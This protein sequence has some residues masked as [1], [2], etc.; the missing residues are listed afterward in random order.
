MRFS[1]AVV[2]IAGGTGGLGAAVSEAFAREGAN[3]VVTYRLAE[4]YQRLTRQLQGSAERLSGEAV[5][6]TDEA[7]TRKFL[8]RVQARYSRVDAL[9][10]TV[11]GYVGGS[12]LWEVEPQVLTRMF[13]INVNPFHSLVRAAL[14]A[15]LARGRGALVNV[16]AKAAIDHPAGAAAYAA[17]KAAALAMTDALAAELHGTG[18]RVNCVL[19]SVIDTPANRQAMPKANFAQWPKPADIAEVILFLC[20]DAARV[21]HGAAI[22]V[23]GNA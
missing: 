18:V 12:K 8:E 21:V 10:N 7:A 4:E 15:F 14:P 16:A 9:V 5:D 22:P 23:Y 2:I 17:S 11:G 6:V 20:S 1:D 19:P 13:T 3:V